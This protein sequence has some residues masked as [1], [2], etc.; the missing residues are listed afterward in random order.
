[1]RAFSEVDFWYSDC[2]GPREVALNIM[3]QWRDNLGIDVRGS[4]ADWSVHM[5]RLSK[6]ASHVW[7]T[8]WIADYP[9]P[10]SYLRVGIVRPRQGE[11]Q[12]AYVELVDRARRLSDQTER[13]DLYRRADRMV[14]EDAV[15][16]PLLYLRGH[17]LIKPW[18]KRYPMI[19]VRPP[20]WKDV[21]IEAH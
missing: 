5:A 1:L 15:V 17:M 20:L 12:Q 16:V 21:V 8:G 2:G 4:G 19:G 7:L 10:D 18:V 13:M 6:A 9:D 3:D 11:T 14:V